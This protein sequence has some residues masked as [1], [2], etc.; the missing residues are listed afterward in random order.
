MSNCKECNYVGSIAA[1]LS[2]IENIAVDT[3][4]L[5]TYT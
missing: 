4:L 3:T 5:T 2:Y 1:N